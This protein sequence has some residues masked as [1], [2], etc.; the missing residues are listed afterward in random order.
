MAN[1]L[2]SL[3][4]T[5][6][7]AL[8]VIARERIG[9]LRG[10][11]RD[12]S[13]GRAALNQTI[14]VP[15]V[16]STTAEADNTPGVTAP[17]TGDQTI[18]N[19]N[20]TISRS[21]HIPVRWNGEET[22]GLNNAGTYQ[23]VTRDRFVQAFRRLSNLIESDLVTEA[24]TNSSRAYGTAGTTPFG[25][26]DDMSD[27]AGIWRILD[28]NGCPT[29]DLHLVLSNA[30]MQNIRGKQA[31]LFRA[32]EAGDTELLR[33]GMVMRVQGFNIHQSGQISAHTKG[34][35]ASYQSNNASGYS[36]G[37]T[38]IAVDTGSG[39]VVAG[40]VVTFTGDTNKYIVG[41]ALSAG[42]LSLS[43]PGLRAALA[44]NVGMA[45]GNNYTPNIAFHRNALGLVTRQP[46]MPDGG[47]SADQVQSITD[48]LTGITYEVALYRQFLQNV[49]HVRLAWGYK[50][51]KQEFIAT[52]LG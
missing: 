1:T 31:T 11:F 43:R 36:I 23:T 17:D 5:I 25:T 33:N 16:P 52:L 9:F 48:P 2:T 24:K 38:G 18:G 22:R 26:T 13:A 51:I 46:A 34:T 37:D 32:N 10:V 6:Y 20:F 21:K 42:N 28:D 35:G 7:E 50:A 19:V 3:I 29:D 40:D 30:A 41:T 14:M 39:T 15:V 27:F 49:I 45:V 12:T 47:D 44:D 4:P 8:D